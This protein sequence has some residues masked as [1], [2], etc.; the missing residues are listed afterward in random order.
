MEEQIQN[1][2]E[3]LNKIEEQINELI[4]Q[5]EQAEAAT[6]PSVDA[7][8]AFDTPASTGQE[9]S[10]SY[11]PDQVVESPALTG[12]K[13]SAS[14]T[15]EQVVESPTS[16]GQDLSTPSV[17]ATSEPSSF[18]T[19]NP[20]GQ[21]SST[22]FNPVVVDPTASVDESSTQSA[23][24]P[25]ESDA[26]SSTSVWKDVEGESS[27]DGS[28]GQ[29]GDVDKINT[30]SATSAE[31]MMARIPLVK[32]QLS[33][34]DDT[35]EFKSADSRKGVPNIPYRALKQISFGRPD[36][37]EEFKTLLESGEK[38][39]I[40]KKIKEYGLTYNKNTKIVSTSK[41]NVTL[42]TKPKGGR[43]SRRRVRIPKTRRRI[44][45]REN[46]RKTRV[47]RV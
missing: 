24:I 40:E 9:L 4:K 34:F 17:D 43:L 35:Y 14:Y 11:T 18:D 29:G 13:L 27:Q 38:S 47:F 30:D 23:T 3:Q 22:S 44:N 26:D 12:Q 37:T 20:I 28:T 46:F 6:S 36:K 41:R 8:S 19:L 1:L 7:P 5:K 42:S 31:P 39:E 2:S 45:V 33:K 32:K 25:N 15:P 16:T 10:V 21:E